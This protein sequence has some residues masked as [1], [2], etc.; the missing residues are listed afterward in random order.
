M[1]CKDGLKGMGLFSLE[2]AGERP[3][4]SP[5]TPGRAAGGGGMLGWEGTARQGRGAAADAGV[6]SLPTG[7]EQR[8][9]R[10]L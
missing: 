2:G 7:S 8:P 9:H 4:A 6:D 3:R 5:R 10:R 1:T